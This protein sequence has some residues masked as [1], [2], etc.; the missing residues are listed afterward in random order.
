MDRKIDV[1][2]I[3]KNLVPKGKETAVKDILKAIKGDN[4]KM[5]IEE[6]KDFLTLW[7][8]VTE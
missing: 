3:R 8:T 4:K 1:I 5:D 6:S 2:R 7:E